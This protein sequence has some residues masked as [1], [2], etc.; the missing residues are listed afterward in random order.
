MVWSSIYVLAIVLINWLFVV[1]PPVPVLGTYFPPVML[2][3]G[4]V[5]VFRDFC[6][7]EVGHFVLLAMLTGGAASYFMSA[8]AVAIA[9]VT[10]FLIS[11]TVDWLV[12]TITKRPLS[13]RILFSSLISV[14]IDTYAF[15]HLVGIFDWTGML[16]VSIAKLTGAVAFWAVLRHRERRPLLA[17]AE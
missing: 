9:S 16:L 14:P 10:A 7:R 11:E 15:L 17:Q 13:E 3:V 1:I 4:F 8:P 12:Y 5:F 6:Q 2:V